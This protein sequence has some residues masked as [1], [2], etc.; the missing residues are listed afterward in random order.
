MWLLPKA[1]LPLSGFVGHVFIEVF[2]YT[3]DAAY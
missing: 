2:R 1:R 3:G